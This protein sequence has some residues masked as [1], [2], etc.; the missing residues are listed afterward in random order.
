MRIRVYIL[1]V[2]VVAA[3]A[4]SRGAERDG[5][6]TASTTPRSDVVVLVEPERE[7]VAPSPRRGL[8]ALFQKREDD[9]PVPTESDA[10]NAALTDALI[11]EGA[12]PVVATEEGPSLTDE[13]IEA[14][15]IVASGAAEPSTRPRLF[16]FL[17][18]RVPGEVASEPTPTEVMLAQPTGDRQPSLTDEEIAARG[19]VIIEV[20]D[21]GFALPATS[22]FGAFAP[23]CGLRK[24]EM[25]I[26]VAQSPGEGTYRLYD[27]APSSALPR[28]QYVT[29][30]KDG[31][32]RQFYAA[33]A[34]FGEPVVHETKRYDRSNKRPYSVADEAYEKVKARV[35]RVA[36]GEF[37]PENRLGRL[38]RDVA[39]LT[40]YPS[41]GG[42]AEWMDVVLFKGTVAGYAV[43]N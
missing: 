16:G 5:F 19:D 15:G 30:F 20:P 23:V 7:S 9:A 18:K 38:G 17:R 33:L 14:R 24:G 12:E 22:G 37:C 4:C 13:E 42:N 11:E 31:C 28:L 10:L 35:C 2:A 29:G 8:F 41:F 25:G 26:E 43:E 39:L 21:T 34:L 36:R 1:L 6:N 32:A 3:A 27:T 40:A